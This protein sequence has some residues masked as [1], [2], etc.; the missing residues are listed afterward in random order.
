MKHLKG[1]II[2]RILTVLTLGLIF[3]SCFDFDNLDEFDLKSGGGEY[4]I[5]LINSKLTIQ[6]VVENEIDDSNIDI[7][8]DGNGLT[9]LR[10]A[11]DVV[12]KSSN[13]VFKP[14]V[15]P[16]PIY[17]DDSTMQM[18]FDQID[19][20]I[21]EKGT[22]RGDSV[23]F[24]FES[25][26]DESI[27]VKIYISETF[28][29]ATGFSQTVNI[30]ANGKLLTEMYP[31]KGYDFESPQ[32]LLTFG[33]DARKQNG[34]RVLLDNVFFEF[35]YFLFDYVQGFVGKNTQ[36]LNEHQIDVSVFDQWESGSL[37]F[38]D[39]KIKVRLDN[40]FGF[41]VKA[42]I[43]HFEIKNLSGDIIPLES[44]V[45]DEDIYFAYPA[46]DEVGEVKS[47]EFY[48]D[49]DNSN[50]AT[51]FNQKVTQ[52]SYDVD[53]IANP[54]NDPEQIGFFIFESYYL[55]NVAVELPMEFKADAFQ[56]ADS[57]E[58]ESL[59]VDVSLVDSFE[60]K[61]YIRNLFPVDCYAQFYFEDESGSLIDSLFMDGEQHFPA[62]SILQDGS[63][64]ANDDGNP[65][66][67]NYDE[68]R[69]DLLDTTNK[70]SVRVRFST[71]SNEE[72]WTKIYKDCGLDIKIGVKFKLK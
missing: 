37:E 70:L 18:R 24:Y 2:L 23:R 62:A 13:E 17:M 29:E 31:L 14:I 3:N 66:F 36:K 61:T 39:P 34:E 42:A 60:L 45:F 72:E 59:P 57:Y 11:A 64:I 41:P 32:N 40:S 35:T 4:A 48:F 5:P 58:I 47:T 20:Y 15:F 52:V 8:Y 33:Y 63:I 9:I 46:L 50:F 26:F 1:K 38:R 68:D 27:Q 56:L 65:L 67:F 12:K 55:L 6:S 30:D 71:T 19:N 21:V 7:D 28:T 16:E 54:E 53:A 10:Y 25:P 69:I 43:N 51:A 49:K 44:P 22:I